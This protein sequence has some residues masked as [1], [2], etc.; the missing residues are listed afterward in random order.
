MVRIVIAKIT[1]C[2]HLHNELHYNGLMTDWGLPLL[3]WRIILFCVESFLFL[4]WISFCRGLVFDLIL[5]FSVSAV[6]LF[7]PLMSFCIFLLSF[8]FSL[9]SL[10]P[11]IFSHEIRKTSEFFWK[12]SI[13]FLKI[14]IVFWG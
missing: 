9:F 14:S 4:P 7:L 11:S 13:V 10:V 6:D 8:S 3:F 2:H 5:T 1:S 12:K